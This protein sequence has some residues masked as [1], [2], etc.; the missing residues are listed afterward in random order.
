MSE[1]LFGYSVEE[2]KEEAKELLERSE[3]IIAKIA[4][5]PSDNEHVN[6][7][8]RAIHSLKGSSGYVGQN[9]INN[10]AHG[11]ESLL[12]ILRNKKQEVT[13]E[14]VNVIQR[15]CDYLEDLVFHPETTEVLH[16]DESITDVYEMVKG[17]FKG[18]T[19]AQP[20]AAAPEP[21][22]APSPT[23]PIQ[24]AQPQE[25]L[26]EEP[27]STQVEAP[28]AEAPQVT[29]VAKP[30]IMHSEEEHARPPEELTAADSPEDFV[31]TEEAPDAEPVDH[32][33]MD[34]GDVIKITLTQSL[35][36]LKNALREDR[37]NKDDVEKYIGK[38]RDTVSWAFGDDMPTTTIAL[39]EMESLVLGTDVLGARELTMLRKG[40]VMMAPEIMRELGIDVGGPSSSVKKEE[41]VEDSRE[42]EQM[43]GASREDIVK[44]ALTNNL[45][46]LTLYLEEENLN[47]QEL[48]K[49]IG[50]LHDLNRWAFNEN[51]EAS[52]SLI[53][54]EDLLKRVDDPESNK[55]IRI[56]GS[57]LKKELMPLIETSLVSDRAEVGTEYHEP[58]AV[59]PVPKEKEI[60]SPLIRVPVD[61][62]PTTPP[63]A[64][65]QEE[66]PAPIQKGRRVVA[67]KA[68]PQSAA[69][70]KIRSEDLENLIGTVGTLKG[71]KEEDFQKLQ[72][73]TLQLR[74]IPVGE[75]FSRF[76][77]VVRDLSEELGKPMRLE[78][79]GESVKLDKAIADKLTEPLMHMV[80]NAAS[81]GIES[82]AERSALGKGPAI[83]KLS[84]AQEGGQVVIQVADNGKGISL[85]K[86]RGK[87]IKLGLIKEEDSVGMTEKKI[88]DLI[89]SP[90]FSTHEGADKIS[91]RGVG[92][93]VVKDAITSI[94]G[95]VS[96]DTRENFG[97][98]FNLQLPL[99]L[100]II[101][102][103]VL[104]Q[105][106]SKIAVP[107]ASVDRVMNMMAKEIEEASFMDKN[108]VCLYLQEEGEVMPIVNFSEVF[109][110]EPSSD[111]RCVVL[112]RIGGGHKVALIVDEAL[113]RQPLTIKP[114]D[115]FSETKY[116]SSASM[117][118]EDVVLILNIPSLLAA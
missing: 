61:S 93:D 69:S 117:I 25:G 71:I 28:V 18:R 108:R 81:H 10:F 7:L 76:K 118:E 96:I 41:E 42:A 62:A 21:V 114:L 55:E 4:E 86:V 29:E 40:F 75:I 65:D 58:V 101:R 37:P 34:Q 11:F 91:G 59:A 1:D 5:D 8:F 115:K 19:G 87:G 63:P 88:L 35:E 94:Q 60:E 39:E 38:L 52:M 89:F 106:D 73:A 14:V 6:A 98:T 53:A 44:I 77:K 99:T 66:R 113:G 27:V 85:A 31:F 15:S 78:L 57:L 105:S 54:M 67:K 32:S 103:L 23:P 95:V 68:S 17:A 92:M 2:F 49:A 45:E 22:Q 50:K 79:S 56:R 112:I 30:E 104:Q 110:F 12:G 80:R 24:E 33:D 3:G 74:M 102:G 64:L 107:A 83:I 84:A 48:H 46:A 43:R 36:A 9:D 16:L 90:G 111:K 20:Q 100:A 109:G 47:V 26:S 70:L 72:A 51:A 13:D 116:F 97:T 82:E